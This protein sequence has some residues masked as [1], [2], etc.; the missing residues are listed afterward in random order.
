MQTTFKRGSLPS[1]KKPTQNEL[2]GIYED[3]LSHKALFF[4]PYLPFAYLLWILIS[5]G[6]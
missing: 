2:S 6:V 5:F 3:V 4:F 1:S